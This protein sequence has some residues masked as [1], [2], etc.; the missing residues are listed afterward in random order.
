MIGMASKKVLNGKLVT[1]LIDYHDMIRKIRISGDFFI[2][3]EESINE[4]EEF[5]VGLDVR[6]EKE[7]IEYKLRNFIRM[8]DIKLI[9]FDE[10]DLTNVIKE[11]VK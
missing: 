3:P 2:H 7:V 9:G 4:I 11:A 6:L 8:R 5:L 10:E 1:V